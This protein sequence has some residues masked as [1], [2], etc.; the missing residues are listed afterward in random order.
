MRF[1]GKVALVTGGGTGIG[2]AAA[3][4]FAAEGATVVVAG[5]DE[6]PVKQTAKEIDATYVVADLTQEADAAAM[7]AATVDRHGALD[8]AF[9]NAG[10][11]VGGPLADLDL[12]SWSRALSVATCTWLSMK[13]E[14]RHMRSH[15]G[16]VIVNMSSIIGSRKGIPGTGAYGAAKAAI[17]AMTRTAALENIGAGIRINSVSPGPIATPFSLIRGENVDQQTERLKTA[18]P[19]GRVG[20]L[21]EVVGTVLWLASPD[22]GYA[23]GSDIVIDGG[24]TA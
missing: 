24:S 20:S 23:V 18:V 3:H 9:N 10:L 7:V 2:R 8:I 13:H 15:G 16:G 12:D 6:E 4:A 14:I 17:T 1:D 11:M 5:I 21:A 22:A 19:I